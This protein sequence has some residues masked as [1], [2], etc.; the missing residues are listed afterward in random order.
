MRHRELVVIRVRVSVRGRVS[1]T[2]IGLVSTTATGRERVCEGYS[3][4]E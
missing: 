1:D 4:R 2:E 3:V